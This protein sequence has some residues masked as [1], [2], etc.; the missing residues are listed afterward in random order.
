MKAKDTVIHADGCTTNLGVIGAICN[1]GAEA[2]AEISFRA[3]YEQR[4][5]DPFDKE[6]RCDKCY[7]QGIR[8]VVEVASKFVPKV[9]KGISIEVGHTPS[10][11]SKW[12]WEC[13]DDCPLCLWQAKLKEWGIK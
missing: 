9:H 11:G 2:Q 7:K 4:E 3:G 5:R 8:E 6:D 10:M 12:K 13:D 1:C